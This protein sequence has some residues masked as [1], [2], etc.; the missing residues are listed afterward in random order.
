MTGQNHFGLLSQSRTANAAF[1]FLYE[2]SRSFNCRHAS[3]TAPPYMSED[4]L[5]AVGL[6]LGTLSVAVSA[7]NTASS[8]MPSSCA[9]TC[10]GPELSARGLLCCLCV[11]NGLP[12]ALL[13][14]FMHAQQL[15]Y[16]LG[17]ILHMLFDQPRKRAVGTLFCRRLTSS[18]R[19]R[20]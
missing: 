4:A 5:A 20:T 15:H 17:K 9:A 12:S 18:G 14:R 10:V 19:G 13:P 7:M 2:A 11:S 3:I 8:G 1:S 6:A 16:H